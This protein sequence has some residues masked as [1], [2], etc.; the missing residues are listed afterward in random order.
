MNSL[1][2]GTGQ[3]SQKRP[4]QLAQHGDNDMRDVWVWA[5]QVSK[6]CCSSEHLLV[7]G[8]L[9][10]PQTR[11]PEGGLGARQPQLQVVSSGLRAVQPRP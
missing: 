10:G 7:G 1:H 9:L 8:E 11:L 5:E 6:V 2:S 4:E 3:G